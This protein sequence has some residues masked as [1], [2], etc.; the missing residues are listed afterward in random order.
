[1]TIGHGR[2]QIARIG[3]IVAHAR[4]LE[5]RG[6]GCEAADPAL[7]RHL[8]N[9][10]LVGAVGEQL[11]LQIRELDRHASPVR[12]C[13]LAA[14]IANAALSRHSKIAGNARSVKEVP[15]PYESNSAR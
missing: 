2:D 15:Q 8:D 14:S 6:I 11:D 4:F 9:L 10:R 1:M 5:Q 12:K 7:L 13:L 3:G